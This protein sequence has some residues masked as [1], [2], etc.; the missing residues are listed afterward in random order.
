[1]LVT[2]NNTVDSEGYIFRDESVISKP[3]GGTVVTLISDSQRV[4]KG[5][6]IANI[7]SNSGNASLQDEINRLQRKLDVLDKSSVESDYM[8]SDISKVDSDISETM[9]DIYSSAGTGDVSK[10]ISTSSTLLVKL[11][12]RSLIVNSEHDYSSESSSLEAQKSSLESRI[13]S[14]SSPVYSPSSGYYYGD[15]DGYESI[16]DLKKIDSMTISEFEEMADSQ[17]NE[18]LITTCAGKIVNDFVWYVVCR[19]NSADMAGINEGDYYKLSFP[20]SADIEIKMQLY[21][22]IS[23]TSS[24]QTLAVFRSNV[25]PQDFS[26]RRAQQV[27]IISGKCEGLAI[28]KIALRVIDGV[29][30]V[31]ILVGDIIHFRR[32]EILSETEDHYIVSNNKDDYVFDD[33]VDE[34][35]YERFRELS[36]YDSVVVSGKDLF[37]GKIVG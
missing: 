10:A 34:N 14:I 33:D 5:Q 31:Y 13:N 35:S 18:S 3:S 2:L 25:I 11:N 27:D 15:V 36:L 17:P 8:I 20:E 24:A 12:K 23:E 26:Y 32:V 28:P 4:S 22:I 6:K 9:N 37:E 29:K 21:R 19:V 1:M 7:Y 16:F 30:G